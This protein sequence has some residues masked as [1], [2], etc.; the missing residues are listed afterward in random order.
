MFRSH[1][2]IAFMYCAAMPFACKAWQRAHRQTF[3]TAVATPNGDNRTS[4][5]GHFFSEN[6]PGSGIFA[7]LSYPNHYN[8]AFTTTTTGGTGGWR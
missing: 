5:S 8:F 1:P 2:R 6:P 7:A 3:A 4:K